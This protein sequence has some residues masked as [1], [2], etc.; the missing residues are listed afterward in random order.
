MS[1]AK[2]YAIIVT[3]DV[4]RRGSFNG[5]GKLRNIRK[6]LESSGTE[7]MAA[8]YSTDKYGVKVSIRGKTVPTKI[9]TVVHVCLDNIKLYRFLG[10]LPINGGK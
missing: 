2:S 5:A 1:V 9:G 10:E 3:P 8:S 6:D 4:C 7:T